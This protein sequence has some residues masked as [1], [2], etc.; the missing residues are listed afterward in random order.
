MN[1]LTSDRQAAVVRALVEGNSLR[2][3][4]RLTGVARNTISDLL[5]DLG[6][7]CKNHHDRFVLGLAPKRVQ[8]DEIWSFCYAK[9][10]NVAPAM[11][12]MG[13]GDVWTWVALDPD[14]K[15]VIT[16]K[17]GSRDMGTC[18]K[19]VDDVATRLV[20]RVQ[21]TSDGL[22]LYERAIRDSFG[23][24]GP[25]VDYGRIVKIFGSTPGAGRYS[26]GKLLSVTK[27]SVMGR[28]DGSQIST[29]LVER[30]N[31]T[32]RMSMRRFTRLTNAFSKKI[33]FHMYAIALH[34][35]YY[36]FCRA[37]GTLSKAAGKQTTPAMAAGLA[38]HQ[39]TVEDMLF[40]LQG[41]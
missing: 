36:N 28:P 41:N 26:P 17:S 40:L 15:L 25:G 13:P 20:A 3:T 29:S 14:S 23:W 1:A 7:H 19:F 5:R 21:I 6:A 38:D 39:W 27:E 34:Y 10:K 16:Y 35:T 22:P 30:Q 12:G 37:H 2:A 4:A 8:M 32:M 18:A 11:K 33:E 24:E 31:L 9:E